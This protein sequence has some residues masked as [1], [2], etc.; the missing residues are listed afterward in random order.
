VIYRDRE[1][2]LLRYKDELVSSDV[3]LI[4]L[5]LLNE[6]T[7]R[8]EFNSQSEQRRLE[9]I[10]K[11]TPLYTHIFT[12]QESFLHRDFL[13]LCESKDT[14]PQQLT[15]NIYSFP[16]FTR[17][18]CLLFLQEIKQFEASPLPRAQPNTMNKYGFLL[19]ELGFDDFMDSLRERYLDDLSRRLFPQYRGEGLDSHRAFIVK[20]SEDEDVDLSYHYDNA[21]VTLNVSLNDSFEGGEVYFGGMRGERDDGRRVRYRHVTSHGVLHRG[22]HMHGTLPIHSGE[23]YNLIIWMRS[24]SLRNQL[25]PMCNQTPSL[26][27]VQ[28][29]TGDGFTA[30]HCTAQ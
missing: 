15:N 16:V 13:K 7:R 2:F 4:L 8:K 19:R 26:I 18:F 11:Y 10:T 6:S 21:E 3:E 27:P 30:T 14:L 17:D 20:Y 5:G 29:G 25:C 1:H 22:Q 24:S 12:L 28:Y 9:I 23:R